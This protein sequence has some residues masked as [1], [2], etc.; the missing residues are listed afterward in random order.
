MDRQIFIYCERAFNAAFWAEPFNAVTNLAFVLA[1]VAIIWLSWHGRAR[2][3]VAANILLGVLITAI[4]VGSFLFHTYASRRML[5][6]DIIPIALFTFTYLS[7]ALK[8]FLGWPWMLALGGAAAFVWFG[9]QARRWGWWFAYAFDWLDL[10]PVSLA[11]IGYVPA[12]LA[13]LL[14]G[15]LAMLR[16]DHAARRAGAQVLLA[17]LVF[18]ASFAFRVADAPLCRDVVLF[19]QHTG[20]HFIWHLLN[21]ASLFLLARAAIRFSAETRK[22]APAPA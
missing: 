16:R 3:G 1:G 15:T 20:T 19:G 18:A 10:P 17:G 11:S 21:A 7:I 12:L 2:P 5:Y 8:R 9:W 22:T 13:M 6:A 14:V 4:G